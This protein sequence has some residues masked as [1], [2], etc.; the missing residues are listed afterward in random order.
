MTNVPQK[1]NSDEIAS[2]IKIDG[3]AIRG[4]LDELVRSTELIHVQDLTVVSWRPKPG[5]FH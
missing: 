4:H 5:R 1:R 3:V 2:A